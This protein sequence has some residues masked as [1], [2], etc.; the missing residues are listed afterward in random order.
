MGG[1]V[2][3]GKMLIFLEKLLGAEHIGWDWGFL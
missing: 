3:L 1:L 2:D